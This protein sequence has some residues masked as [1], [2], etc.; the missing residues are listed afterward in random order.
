MTTET[1]PKPFYRIGTPGKPWTEVE[2]QLWR[3]GTQVYR[4]YREEVRD[5]LDALDKDIWEVVQTGELSH[6]PQ[7]YPLFGVKSRNWASGKQNVL[8]TGG[9]HGYETSGV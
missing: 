7:R 3:A 8:V 1:E 6:D 5:K 9:V 2:H 4:S